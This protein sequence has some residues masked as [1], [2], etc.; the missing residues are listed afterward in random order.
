MDLK[1]IKMLNK[2]IKKVSELKFPSHEQI[3]K[4]AAHAVRHMLFRIY[5]NNDIP[6]RA[7]RIN[8]HYAIEIRTN[9]LHPK[10]V[11]QGSNVVYSV[12]EHDDG[13][14]RYWFIDGMALDIDE[15]F[16]MSEEI[17]LS[18]EMGKFRRFNES[19]KSFAWYFRILTY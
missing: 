4:R 19:D 1:E 12:D 18:H 5:Q 16:G 8:G 6:L 9:A 15:Y 13:I 2:N 14:K 3:E 17:L 11:S 7:F 10:T